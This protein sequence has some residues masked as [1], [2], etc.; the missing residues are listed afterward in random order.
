MSL[1][2]TRNRNNIQIILRNEVIKFVN[3]LNLE[4]NRFLKPRKSRNSKMT[5]YLWNSF[6]KEIIEMFRIKSQGKHV[7]SRYLTSNY[8][9]N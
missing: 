4:I 2:K 5:I 3:F 6:I 9:I 8:V 1:T 7:R